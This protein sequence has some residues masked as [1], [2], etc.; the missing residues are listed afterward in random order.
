MD[1]NRN[2]SGFASISDH[3]MY[4]CE[5]VWPDLHCYSPPESP[6]TE[7][8]ENT[9]LKQ[10]S[11]ETS[12]LEDLNTR[13]Q[14]WTESGNSL[15]LSLPGTLSYSLH[16]DKE[17]FTGEQNRPLSPEVQLVPLDE[18]E[19]KQCERKMSFSESDYKRKSISPKGDLVVKIED[20]KEKLKPCAS[21]GLTVVTNSAKVRYT[22]SGR[23]IANNYS[24]KELANL[25]LVR[26]RDAEKKKKKR[27]A[28]SKVPRGSTQARKHANKNPSGKRNNPLL[29]YENLKFSELNTIPRM[30]VRYR[31]AFAKWPYVF[32]AALDLINQR[33]AS[34]NVFWD[35]VRSWWNYVI[36]YCKYKWNLL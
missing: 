23:K 34:Q 7:Q 16:S 9:T 26:A 4:G 35:S 6:D 31:V 15:E 11:E 32:S 17:H 33:L 36:Y 28:R 10:F 8:I 12:E 3:V 30:S 20:V 22:S 5:D 13:T 2:L 24:E 14:T 29:L 19:Y 1:E 25:S 27:K 18:K 21:G